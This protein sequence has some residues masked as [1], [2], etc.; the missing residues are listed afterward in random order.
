MPI[1]E[2]ICDDC[3][4]R[5]EQI[6]LSKS[7]KIACPKCDSGK[8]TVQLSVF[9]A[10]ANGSKSSNGGS[11]TSGVPSGGGCCGGACGCH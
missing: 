8:H 6:V 1:F 10:P 11:S 9:A 7:T 3:G 5:Y 2:Y 4:E